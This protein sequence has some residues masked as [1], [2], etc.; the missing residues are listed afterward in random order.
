MLTDLQQPLP[1]DA[2]VAVC[3]SPVTL[4]FSLQNVLVVVGVVAVA[5]LAACCCLPDMT[6]NVICY[7]CVVVSWF[8][9]LTHTA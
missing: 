3:S 4:A 8:C 9:F 1:A 6:V 7:G 2:W 5:L